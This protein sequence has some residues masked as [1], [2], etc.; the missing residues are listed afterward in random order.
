MGIFFD[1][2]KEEASTTFAI[3]KNSMTEVARPTNVTCQ[4]AKRDVPH[5]LPNTGGTVKIYSVGV[6]R[7]LHENR[8]I[9]WGLRRYI[10][11]VYCQYIILKMHQRPSAENRPGTLLRRTLQNAARSKRLPSVQ[12]EGEVWHFPLT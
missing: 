5:T 9:A 10:A 12:G 4:G 7:T 6:A 2:T 8:P 11:V 1:Q 3:R